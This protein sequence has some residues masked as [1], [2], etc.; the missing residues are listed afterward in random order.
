M[1][2]LHKMKLK[3]VE[4]GGIAQFT[5]IESPEKV[6][7]AITFHGAFSSS[8]K[9]AVID[10]AINAPSRCFMSR[11]AQFGKDLGEAGTLDRL[12]EIYSEFL[13][14]NGY[15]Q[16]SADELLT[17]PDVDGV[18]RFWLTQFSAKFEAIANPRSPD[19]SEYLVVGRIH[20]ASTRALKVKALDKEHAK[21]VFADTVWGEI[22]PPLIGVRE[23]NTKHYGTD[24]QID[25]VA[26]GDGIQII[27]S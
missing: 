27:T 6:Q 14:F 23:A 4:A 20:G 11:I 24:V 21:R 22:Q 13:S 7:F 15:P 16:L 25:V 17:E 8:E 2:Q 1:K 26:V 3:A 19:L 5:D 18:N 9:E 10:A 12:N